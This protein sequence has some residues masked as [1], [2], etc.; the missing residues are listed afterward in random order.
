M[1]GAFALKDISIVILTP[2]DPEERAHWSGTPHYLIAE[3]RRRYSRVTVISGRQTRLLLRLAR[4]LL[5]LWR[6]DPFREMLTAR[7]IA[8]ANTRKIARLNPDLVFGVAASHMIAGLKTAAPLVHFS[9]ATFQA[10]VGY[11]GEFSGL[12]PRTVRQGN[13][14]EHAALH[15]ADAVLLA[16]DWAAASAI[17]DYGLAPDR[18]T[19]APLG[20]NIEAWPTFD[21]DRRPDGVC[22]LLFVGIDW[23]RKGGDVAYAV[24]RGLLDRGV[25]AELHVAGCDPPIPEDAPG[26]RRHG[27]LRKSDPVEFE[28]LQQ[29]YQSATFFLLPTRAE[30]YGLVF[31]EASAFGLPILATRTGGVPSVVEAEVSGLLFDVDAPASACTF[32]GSKRCGVIPT[33]TNV[34]DGHLAPSS[35]AT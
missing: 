33:P 23:E 15:R 8:W 7:L 35:N 13:R 32:R 20:A 29:L 4:W 31:A 21:P 11:Y 2:H 18:I 25:E 5:R 24:L 14:M 3:M 17:T 16:S 6:I 26:V 10:V 28:R 19:V 9:D 34:L 1:K 27:F 30:A 12:S 22:R